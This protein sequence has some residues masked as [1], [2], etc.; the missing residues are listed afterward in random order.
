MGCR[1]K[2]NLTGKQHDVYAK[3]VINA[4]G[5]FSDGIRQMSDSSRVSDPGEELLS[6]SALAVCSR[7]HRCRQI[8]P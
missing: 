3:L 8:F 4:T 1:V 7:A 5:P 6:S 2:D